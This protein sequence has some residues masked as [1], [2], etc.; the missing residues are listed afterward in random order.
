MEKI[1]LATKLDILRLL[2]TRLSLKRY[3]ELT[4]QSESRVMLQYPYLTMPQPTNDLMNEIAYWVQYQDICRKLEYLTGGEFICEGKPNQ[5]KLLTL[6]YFSKVDSASSIDI[7]E[8]FN[9]SLANA[10]RR[11]RLYAK[12]QGLLDREQLREKRRGR[13]T[14]VYKLNETG[15]KRLAYLY[16]TISLPRKATEISEKYRICHWGMERIIYDLKKK[17]LKRLKSEQINH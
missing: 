1:D 9:I 10:T 17:L 14:F 8:K 12:Q 3:A 7:K 16:K 5:R 11:L 4:G 13:P 2:N 15:K 6:E